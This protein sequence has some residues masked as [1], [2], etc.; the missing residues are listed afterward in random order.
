MRN[1]IGL[2][3]GGANL[4][5]ADTQGIACSLPFALWRSPELLAE[6]IS[7]LLASV[8]CPQDAL[9]AL[10]MTGEL[11]DCY[12]TKAEG[13]QQIIAATT[14]AIGQ[15]EIVVATVDDRWLSPSEA[16]AVPH[17]VAAA[18]WR[19][20]AR[21]GAWLLRTKFNVERG[22]LI[23]VGSTTIDLAP[24]DSGRVTTKGTNDTERLIQNELLYM[25]VRR[26]PICALLDTLLYRGQA[27]PL[28][29]EWF[30]TTEDAWLLLEHLT[31]SD[32]CDTADGRP[33]QQR[34]AI[35]RLARCLGAD[36]D[37]YT[38]EDALAAAIQ[39][40]DKQIDRLA[41]AISKQLEP[42]KPDA[43]LLCGE[44]EFLAEQALTRLGVELPQ[45]RFS[46][47]HGMQISQCGPAF[48]AAQ[49]A[50]QELA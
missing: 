33:R 14:S 47:I 46:H 49:L 21:Y 41:N 20:L 8:S 42:N 9:I 50:S 28:M 13:V 29:A 6:Q 34:Y 15:R 30:A 2:D 45:H 4:K 18:N 35:A 23:D 48:A 38:K 25:G 39:I 36:T 3:I 44:G 43:L 5:L 40:A 11:A 22:L 27:C 1:W 32:S 19:L 24:F 31:E 7:Q 10:T 17:L 16:T 26:T 12:E 37:S